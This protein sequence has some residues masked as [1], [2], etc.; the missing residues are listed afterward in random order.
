MNMNQF[1]TAWF[2]KCEIAVVNFIVF[3]VIWSQI[4][5]YSAQHI[6]QLKIDCY[7]IEFERET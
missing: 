3:I 6:Q 7:Q 4:E 1:T 2:A 5:Y